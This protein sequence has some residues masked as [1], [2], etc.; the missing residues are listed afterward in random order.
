[1]QHNA[2]E[3]KPIWFSYVNLTSNSF[4]FAASLAAGKRYEKLR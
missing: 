3:V 2:Y 1:M 4:K